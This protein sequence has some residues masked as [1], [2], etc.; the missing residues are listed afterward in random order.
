MRPP[1]IELV[2]ELALRGETMP[3]KSTYFYPKLPSGLA[4]FHA[5]CERVTDWL[6]TCRE[7]RRG[8]AAGPG[9]N[10]RRGAERERVVGQGMG[11]DETTAIDEAAER[12]VVERLDATGADF[13][14]VSEELGIRP[15]ARGDLSNVIVLDPIDGSINA[16]R[17][18]PFF[19]L[20]I[21]VADGST[22]GDVVFGYVYDFGVR[23]GVDGRR[24]AKGAILDDRPLAT[25]RA[26]D[27]GSS[28][29]G[30]RRRGPT[31]SPATRPRVAPIA[32]ACG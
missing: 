9:R 21:A 18:I 5:G 7:R 30:S 23:R 22:M 20:S 32:A 8:R 2:R 31:S 15:P 17:G 27:R 10:A 25:V 14:L 16:K 28:C 26:A 29:S 13:T 4:V 12:T 3:Q 6:E 1:S 19:S 24:A 11:G